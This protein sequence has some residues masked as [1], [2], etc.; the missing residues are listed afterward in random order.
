MNNPPGLR[1][2]LVGTV[3]MALVSAFADAFW[4]AALPEHR[5][6]YGLVHGAIVLG[7]LGFVLARLGKS[8]RAPLAG[9]GGVLV[10]VFAAALFYLLYGP[11][12]NLA[13][14][15]AWMALWVAFAFLNDLAVPASETGSRTV[16]RGLVAAV[17]SGIAFWMVSGMWLGPHDPGPLYV[18][19]ALNWAVA[20]LPG[21]LALLLWRPRD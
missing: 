16:T 20:F 14:L 10:G 5:T 4:A 1:G 21:F 12:G 11:I 2:A 13:L 7:V 18:R 3:I 6:I 9:A 17:A 19:N 8:R 15:I